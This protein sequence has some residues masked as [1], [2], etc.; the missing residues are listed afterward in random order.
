MA[1]SEMQRNTMVRQV[2][3]NQDMEA[4]RHDKIESQSASGQAKVF[5]EESKS[6]SFAEEVKN[7]GESDAKSLLNSRQRKR[8]KQAQKRKAQQ[9][10]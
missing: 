9:S 1:K 5:N 2:G 6:V 8:Q 7:A 4:A 10:E 3:P